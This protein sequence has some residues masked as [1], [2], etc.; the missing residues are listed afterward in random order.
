MLP[1]YGRSGKTGQCALL[2]I[3]YWLANLS[4]G[5]HTPYHQGEHFEMPR[6]GS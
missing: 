1:T 4:V 2:L 3:Y 6:P 5:A